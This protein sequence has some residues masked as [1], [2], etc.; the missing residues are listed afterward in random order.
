M[1]KWPSELKPLEFRGLVL[2]GVTFTTN[3]VSLLFDKGFHV[4]VESRLSLTVGGVE[5]DVPIPPTKT[6]LT[7]LLGKT[8]QASGIDVDGASLLL[9]FNDGCQLRLEGNDDQYEC[10]HIRA[11]GREFTV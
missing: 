1:Y 5:E 10:F 8:V 7:C 11:K 6:H 4:T 2:E 9:T 3:T